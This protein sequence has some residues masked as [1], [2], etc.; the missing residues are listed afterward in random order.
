MKSSLLKTTLAA[1]CFAVLA[2][3]TASAKFMT[4]ALPASV[5]VAS[6][7]ESA[8]IAIAQVRIEPILEIAI[9]AVLCAAKAA[10]PASPE[11]INNAS[12]V[13]LPLAVIPEPSSVALLGAASLGF[14]AL[15]RRRR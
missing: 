14:L 13:G 10:M 7:A 12:S 5:P 1:W 3:G 11:I 6:I 15:R 2:V 4:D 9:D 8:G